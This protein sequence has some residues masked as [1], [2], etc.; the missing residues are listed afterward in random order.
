MRVLGGFGF[1]WGLGG[2]GFRVKGVAWGFSILVA[3][4]DPQ[5][6]DTGKRRY[7]GTSLI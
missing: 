4:A 1:F 7:R 2:L 3:L 5:S 6:Q